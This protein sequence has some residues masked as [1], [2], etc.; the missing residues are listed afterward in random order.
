MPTVL[1]LEDWLFSTMFPQPFRITLSS[2]MISSLIF[3]I[4][5]SYLELIYSTLMV[6]SI[7]WY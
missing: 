5:R 2:F 1:I 4:L 6:D 3:F 7:A